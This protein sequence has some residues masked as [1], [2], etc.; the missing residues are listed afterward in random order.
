MFIYVPYYKLYT[1]VFF[2]VVAFIVALHQNKAL[3]G[4]HGL[5]PADL[6][7]NNIKR[8]VKDNLW[9][10]IKAV[11]TLLW[12]FDYDNNV[13]VLLDR[14]AYAG[15]A[16]SSFVFI[17]GSANIILMLTLWVLYHSIVNVGQTW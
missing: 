15:L 1:A 9:G 7:L 13:N 5:L 10:K 16:L 11:P 2:S 8:Q 12:F 17:R 14:L 3:I 6:Y 4:K